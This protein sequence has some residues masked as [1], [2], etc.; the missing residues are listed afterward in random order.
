MSANEENS[1]YNIAV[2][3]FKAYLV[4]EELTR[5]NGNICRAAIGLGIHRNSITRL[6]A[7]MHIDV[8]QIKK[9]CRNSKQMGRVEQSEMQAK[10]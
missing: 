8:N 7:E 10:G 5:S 4:T 9:T 1:K 3:Q 2:R 6:I